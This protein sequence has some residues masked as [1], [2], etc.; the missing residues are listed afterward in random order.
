MSQLRPQTQLAGIGSLLKED[1]VFFGTGEISRESLEALQTVFSIE[2]VITKSDRT[3]NGRPQPTAVSQWANEHNTPLHYADSAEEIEGVLD[4]NRLRS[5]VAVVVDYGVI[6]PQT[7]IDYFSLG[8][9]NSHFSLL[10]RYRGSNPIRSPL[11][12]GDKQTG[13]TLIRITAGLDEGPI[14]A[15]EV[16]P[17]AAK[18]TTPSLTRKLI[19]KSNAM[20][21]TDTLRYIR[22]EISPAPQDETKA[23]WSKKTSKRDGVIDWSK[24]AEQLDREIRA[25]L[26]WPKS[27]TTLG[28]KEVVITQAR[29]VPTDTAVAS[30]P[31][32]LK[33]ID[34]ENDLVV[35]A[36]SGVLRIEKLKPAGKKEMSAAEFIRG[37]LK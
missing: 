22:G 20:L 33:V 2:A 32:E 31:G 30:S 35:G 12:A 8:I 18:E 11:L 1:C 23:T 21:T 27:R 14:I 19:E 3:V 4:N 25:Y 9:I 37:Y 29:A 26:D 6:I 34:D 17:L 7:V 15:R 13:V 28:K 10:P 5:Q 36:G 24:P 16:V